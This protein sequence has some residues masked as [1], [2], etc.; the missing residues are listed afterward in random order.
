MKTITLASILGVAHSAKVTCHFTADNF[1]HEVY[2]DGVDVLGSVKGHLN[3]WS[4][5][6]EVTF[7]SSATTLAIHASD[8]ENGCSSGGFIMQCK[9]SD[10]SSPW[11]MDTQNHRD[12]FSVAS[13]HE[14]SRR[15]IAPLANQN[16]PAQGWEKKDFKAVSTL[17]DTPRATKHSWMRG[18]RWGG[19]DINGGMCSGEGQSSRNNNWWYRFSTDTVK[20][21]FTADNY[22]HQVYVDGEQI[23][24]EIDGNLN[25]W[26][27]EKTVS[28]KASAQ[29][30][31]IHASDAEG[32]C[33]NG[34]FIMQCRTAVKDSPWNM[35]TDNNRE[36]FVVASKRMNWKGHYALHNADAPDGADGK[37]WHKKNFQ[38]LDTKW[39]TPRKTTHHWMRGSR[40]GGIDINGGICSG[41]SQSDMN[42]N[43]WIRYNINTVKCD[44]T[45][46]NF[47][48]KI[49]VDGED[50]SKKVFGNKNDWTKEKYIRFD[51]SAKSIAVHASDAERGCRNGGF[52]MACTTPVKNSKW[53]VNTEHDRKK[54]VVA[55]KG[56]NHVGF[57]KLNDAKAPEADWYKNDFYAVSKAWDVPRATTHHWMRNRGIDI[58]HG[59]CAGNNQA[60]TNN[61]WWI[62][63]E[64]KDE[65]HASHC[66]DWD[67]SQWCKCFSEDLEAKN[68]YAL[69][70]CGV[71][72]ENDCNCG[73]E[74]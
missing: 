8:Y 3:N 28:F 73:I 24:R 34:G 15:G 10:P 22:I 4:H 30:L 44:L 36:T 59:I 64:H 38:P 51:S 58:N 16:P 33:R 27:T 41:N 2:V 67:C 6:K 31:A 56:M 35:N 18:S 26:T 39:D 17:W 14:G 57:Q 62:R 49:Y 54:F 45:A 19:I 23:N 25:S 50:M 70:G 65:C 9:T 60:S 69:S 1:I 42:N 66:A 61:N 47:V 74:E 46:D 40:W 63:L 52:M 13:R 53:N 7:D 43:W 5:K 20:C 37:S 12:L 32:G 55:S 29:A 11:N 21:H 48:H 72:G 68:I 71:S